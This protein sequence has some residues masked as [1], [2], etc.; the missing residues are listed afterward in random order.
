MLDKVI[1]DGISHAKV[2]LKHTHDSHPSFNYS[3][4]QQKYLELSCCSFFQPA[5]E[6]ISL[7]L[8]ILLTGKWPCHKELKKLRLKPIGRL[9]TSSGAP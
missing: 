1:N 2:V 9:P 8:E 3:T 6:L 4:L 7:I 5:P